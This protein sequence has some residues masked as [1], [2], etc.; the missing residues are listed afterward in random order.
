MRISDHFEASGSSWTRRYKP[1]KVLE[2]HPSTS[3]CDEQNLT[4]KYMSRHGMDN[5]RGGP[6]CK[7]KLTDAEKEV[8]GKMIQSMTDCCYKCREKGHFA[9]KCTACE[10]CRRSNHDEANC[11]AKTDKFGN[12]ISS[13]ESDYSEDVEVVDCKYGAVIDCVCERCGRPNHDITFCFAKKDVDGNEILLSS[14]EYNSDYT[15]YDEV[16]EC[17][18]ARCG[19]SN[20]DAENCFAKTDKY[21]NTIYRPKAEP[22][23]RPKAKPIY[24]PKAEPKDRPKPKIHAAEDVWC[25]SFCDRE[26]TSANGARY[27]EIKWCKYRK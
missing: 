24:R 15:E 21:G 3:E 7:A 13:D 5:V 16:M 26:F 22:N 18:C 23:D 19:R 6:W 9:N 8:I 25:C 2:I 11:F 4:Q 20:H 12:E 27:H 17:V 14:D 10:R 1:V